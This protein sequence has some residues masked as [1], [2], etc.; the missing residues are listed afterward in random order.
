MVAVAILIFMAISGQ[1]QSKG[2]Q[3]VLTPNEIG[4]FKTYDPE[5]SAEAEDWDGTY[6]YRD[7]PNGKFYHFG[8]FVSDGDTQ[9]DAFWE[10]KEKFT[11]SSTLKP[12]NAIS[13]D[14]DNLRNDVN[15]GGGNR[16]TTWCEGVP[17]YGIGERINMSVI[18]KAV[19][20]DKEEEI[21]FWMLMIV[22]GYAKDATTWKNNTRVQ[23]L[24][25]YV[26]GNPWCDLQL[27]DVMKPQVF[28]LPEDLYIY[29]G[30]SGRKIPEKDAFTTPLNYDDFYDPSSP[31]AFSPKIPV[32]Q[33]DLSFEIIE[34]Y[35]GDKFDDTC[36]TGIALNTT[37]GIY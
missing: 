28:R 6:L 11:A 26:G 37:G 25:L 21:C 13:Y 30:K 9:W 15:Q 14:A 18:T 17:G 34:V 20:M 27:N 5:N 31:R 3:T 36:I 1:G 19:Y 32:F 16:A 4:E 24:R 7:D 10:Y 8:S 29:P 23:I 2:Q 12:S 35:P 33:T 22:N